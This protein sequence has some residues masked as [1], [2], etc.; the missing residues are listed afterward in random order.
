MAFLVAFLARPVGAGAGALAVALEAAPGGSGAPRRRAP[1]ARPTPASWRSSRCSTTA[2]WRRSGRRAARQRGAVARR[3]RRWTSGRGS[4]GSAPPG[5]SGAGR[6]SGERALD[7]RR[8]SRRSRP[9]WAARWRWRRSALRSHTCAVY[10]LSDDEQ[11]SSC[12]TAAPPATRRARASRRARGRWAARC[13]RRA[14]V[15]LHGE[16]KGGSY[17]LDGTPPGRAAGGAALEGAAATCAGCWWRT[18]CEPAPF[19]ERGRA[20]AATLGRR[21]A[22][23]DR[24]RAGD[25]RHEQDPRREGA[26]LPGHRGAQPGQQAGRGVRRAMEVAR[27]VGPV[28][29]AR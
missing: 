11:R 14:P 24:G 12:T 25:G 22:A 17:Y 2:C 29:F 10:L 16:L 9:R 6:R 18:G 8:R 27:A 5:P 19:T 26:V 21:G 1:V 23:R 28:D 3:L 7:R 20:A 4:T 13:A 15:R